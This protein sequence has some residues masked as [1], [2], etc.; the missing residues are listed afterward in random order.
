MITHPSSRDSPS[1]CCV[2]WLAVLNAFVTLVCGNFIYPDFNH[3]LGLVFNG[4]AT[5]TDCGLE[6]HIRSVSIGSILSP[7]SGVDATGNSSQTESIAPRKSE[8]CGIQTKEVTETNEHTNY[9]DSIRWREA[10]FGHRD[11]FV[12]SNK[13]GCST[14]LRLTDS[15]PSQAGSVWYEKRLPVLTGFD[16]IFTFQVSDHS[17]QCS[18]HHDPTFSLELYRSCV[19][20]GGDGFAF[21]I[22][23]DPKGTSALGGD[24]EDLGYG[25]TSNSLA[26][27]FDTW[28]NVDTQGS[29][30]VF[31]D[32][33]SV[34]SG[35]VYEN[36]ADESTTLG[37][38]RATDLADGK[39]HATRIRYLPF[40]ATQYFEQMTANEN[41]LPYLR[42]NGEG[43][44]LGTLV[45]FIDDGIADDEPILAIPINLSILLDLP[46]S[47]AYV[48]FT[49]AN[50][51][52]SFHIT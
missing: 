45:V 52:Y 9:S 6:A 49:G 1:A 42:D 37:Y 26:I 22:H 43:R 32:H 44:R 12:P 48:G 19:V 20:H 51:I 11:Y 34:H 29:D 25:G 17:R 39:V 18:D 40:V 2:T 35:S 16:T 5:T 23:S 15:V 33:I 28:T 10:Q 31:Y 46:Q 8:K 13:T 21:L 4:N 41:L 38:W 7:A 24:G 36:R 50:S 30:D 47:L 3:T 14:R 27:E